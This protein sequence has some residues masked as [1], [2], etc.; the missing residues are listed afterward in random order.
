MIDPSKSSCDRCKK[1]EADDV[2]DAALQRAGVVRVM[3]I[4][5]LFSA[6]QLLSTRQRVSNNRLAIITNGGGLGVMA[7]DRAIDLGVT[8][9]SLSETTLEKLNKNL[10]S[11]WSHANPIDLL[12]DAPAERYLLATK[13]R[14]LRQHARYT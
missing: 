5:Q 9:A 4:E 13:C 6:A 7:T 12:G 8:L 14:C 10:P 2:F 3:T 11:Q 1:A